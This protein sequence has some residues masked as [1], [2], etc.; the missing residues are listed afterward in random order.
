MDK[1]FFSKVFLIIGVLVLLPS[2]SFAQETGSAI[3]AAVSAGAG[4][5]FDLT[6]MLLSPLGYAILGLTSLITM[7]AGVLL[8]ATIYFTIIE[9]A[10]NFAR[11]APTID[12][13]WTTIRDVANMGFIFMLLWSSIQL[14]IGQDS[15]VRQLIV[16]II[17]AALLVNFSLF[18]TKVII[19]L[20][21]LL[22]LSFYGAIVPADALTSGPESFTKIG[23][24][25]AIMS[26]LGVTT[27]FASAGTFE[28]A[29][30]LFTISILSSVVLLI[31]SFIFF[32]MAIMLIIRYVVLIFVLIL[33]PIAFVSWVLPG[34]KSTAAKWWDTLIGQAIFAPIFFLLMW[35]TVV[36]TRG[37]SSTVFKDGGGFGS[38]FASGGTNLFQSNAVIT[39]I[40]FMVII[41]FL[42]ASLVIAKQQADKSHG[43]IKSLTKWA[44]GAASGAVFGGALGGLGRKTLGKIGANA[45]GD[46][47]LIMRAEKETGLRGA[48]ARLNLYA[49]KKMAG[50]SYDVRNMSV[51]GSVVADAIRGTAG[52]TD[53]GK[54]MGLNDIRLESLNAGI[55]GFAA[56]VAGVGSGSTSSYK[57]LNSEKDKRLRAESMERAGEVKKAEDKIKIKEGLAA[58]DVIGPRT[59]D[60]EAAIK[61]MVD[62]IKKTPEKDI[63]NL[64]ASTLEKQEVAEALSQKQM[65]AIEKSDKFTAE[66]VQKIKAARGK[67]LNDAYTSNNGPEIISILQKMK[68][69]DVAKLDIGK[70]TDPNM[71]DVYT[72]KFLNKLA[73]APDLN[74]AKATAIRDAIINAG[75]NTAA[76][77]WLNGPGQNIY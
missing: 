73:K 20:T 16:N 13:A 68:H 77:N 4:F 41:G 47:D 17:L 74:D 56:G 18:F 10:N 25:N 60:Q 3:G 59:L 7:L 48:R 61:N 50:G 45:A 46:A 36:V 14:I 37:I 31:T 5:G 28:G 12:V 15:N 43:A 70:L 24:S 67:R 19:D 76:I 53:I 51:P 69:E 8:N 49:A 44:T 40:N 65:E 64:E 71:L 26:A 52:R 29:G 34:L 62:V 21:N 55:G 33:S 22:A 23:L 6:G 66:E 1:K 32:A 75:T 72:P 35:V 38:A 2:L 54:S 11:V 58:L 9:M 42:I 63:E 27:I 57:E 39:I 30:T